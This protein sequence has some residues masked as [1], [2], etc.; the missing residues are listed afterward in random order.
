MTPESEPMVIGL[1][2]LSVPL[3]VLVSARRV[4]EAA[5]ASEVRYPLVEPQ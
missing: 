3:Q 1:E 2:N 5:P 4:E